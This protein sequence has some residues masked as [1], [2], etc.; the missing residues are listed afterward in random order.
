LTL[1]GQFPLRLEAVVVLVVTSHSVLAMLPVRAL[2][3]ASHPFLVE[4]ALLA[5]MFKFRVV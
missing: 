1:L 2:L 4:V 3:V 5:E